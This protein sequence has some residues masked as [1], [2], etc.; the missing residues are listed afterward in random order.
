MTKFLLIR[1]ATTDAVGKCLSGRKAGVHLNAMGLEQARTLSERLKH[2]PI[3]AVYS[4]PLE[5]ALETAAPLCNLIDQQ[6]Q[7]AEEFLE[8]DFGHWTNATFQELA[9]DPE[10]ERFNTFRSLTRIP[11]GESMQ[12]AQTRMISG[13][14]RLATKH[15][16]EVVAVFSHSDMI[17]SA[18][19]HYAGIHLDLFQRIEISPASVSVVEIF[20]D[21]VR[22]VTINNTGTI[23]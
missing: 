22:L 17:K 12:E 6:C 21:A 8:L 18:I 9:A 1:H 4:S 15:P 23:G 11:G 13:L 19:A 10:F 7:S 14:A 20:E 2:M 5:R 16:N 3:A